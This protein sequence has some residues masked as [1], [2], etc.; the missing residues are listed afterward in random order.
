MINQKKKIKN[1]KY[2]YSYTNANNSSKK[3]NEKTFIKNNK[4]VR[5]IIMNVKTKHKEIN[6]NVLNT[7][8]FNTFY[9]SGN[10]CAFLQ[11]KS[12]TENNIVINNNT[13]YNTVNYFYKKINYTKNS[14]NVKEFTPLDLL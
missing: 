3:K 11:E 14:K 4:P 1:V 10:E 9:N 5:D 6:R 7:N 12:I 8:F 2:M 13:N